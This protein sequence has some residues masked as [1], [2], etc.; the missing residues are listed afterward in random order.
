MTVSHLV[1]A[2]LRPFLSRL[3]EVSQAVRALAEEDDATAVREAT[4]GVETL[5]PPKLDLL[6]ARLEN[7]MGPS[8]SASDP[9]IE[10][11]QLANGING[12]ALG[13]GFLAS[14]ATLPLTLFLPTKQA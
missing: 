9:D 13:E 1:A 4:E 2:H 6:R 8:A 14:R 12:L 3:V 5:S 11:S 10:I 7:G